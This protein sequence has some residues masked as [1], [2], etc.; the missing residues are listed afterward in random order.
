MSEQTV[1]RTTMTPQKLEQIWADHLAQEFVNKDVEAALATLTE[2]A[3]IY[4]GWAPVAVG[5]EKVRAFYNDFIPSL[6]DDVQAT[7]PKRVI[8]EGH[9]LEWLALLEESFAQ[10]CR[11]NSSR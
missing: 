5:K 4:N 7:S 8:G 3:S 1:T 11:A 6:P 2:D 9:V 10:D